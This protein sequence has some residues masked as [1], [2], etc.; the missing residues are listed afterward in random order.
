MDPLLA[1]CKK[2]EI[3]RDLF[4]AYED[5]N[6]NSLDGKVPQVCIEACQAC[7]IRITCLDWALQFEAHGYWGGTRRNAR[8]KLRK[9]LG[10]RI[11]SP[12]TRPPW[13][14]EER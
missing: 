2:R 10:I 9:K 3:P 5:A 6:S 11:A 13:M 12:T 1:E 14:A 4:F 8:M 7:E